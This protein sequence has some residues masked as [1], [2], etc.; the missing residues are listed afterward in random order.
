MLSMDFP[1]V[2]SKKS[3]CRPINR[4]NFKIW[5]KRQRTIIQL[6]S[7]IYR[8]MSLLGAFKALAS[9]LVQLI[10]DKIDVRNAH[11][12]YLFI[13]L[14]ICPFFRSF[15]HSISGRPRKMNPCLSCCELNFRMY[16]RY[17]IFCLWCWCYKSVKINIQWQNILTIFYAIV[18]V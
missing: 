2:R 11:C 14:F 1:A 13:N 3:K 5:L 17:L 16:F 18:S 6:K 9:H 10:T 12:C 4:N 7:T 8:S 15:I